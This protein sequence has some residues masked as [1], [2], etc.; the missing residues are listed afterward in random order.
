MEMN[1]RKGL[2]PAILGIL[3]DINKCCLHCCYGRWT[4]CA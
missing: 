1:K 2:H 4:S 3:V